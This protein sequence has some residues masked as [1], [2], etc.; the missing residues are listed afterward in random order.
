MS[1]IDNNYSVN[2]DIMLKITNNIYN[3]L[4]FFVLKLQ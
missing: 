3:I 4:S 1:R 2:Y